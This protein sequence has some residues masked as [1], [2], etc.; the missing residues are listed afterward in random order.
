[1]TLVG[2]GLMVSRC[3]DAAEV[4]AATGI[5]ARV[6]EVHTIKPLDSESS[7]GGP[8]DRRHRHRRRATMVGG[9]GGAVLEAIASACPVPVER[10]GIMDEF[11]TSGSYEMLLEHLGLTSAAVAAA[12]LRALA[13]KSRRQAGLSEKLPAQ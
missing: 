1:M 4:L 2:T 5:D 3:L 8:G 6:I 11:A 10:V 9:L 7:P 13:A 12:A